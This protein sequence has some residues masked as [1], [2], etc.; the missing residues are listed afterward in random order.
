MLGGPF[1]VKVF[2]EGVQGQAGELKSAH[3]PFGP[4]EKFFTAKD[5]IHEVI[6]EG[7]GEAHC[8][9]ENDGNPNCG[10]ECYGQPG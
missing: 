2:Y 9:F 10:K 7:P 1:Y 8:E 3:G 5:L 6:S 4:G